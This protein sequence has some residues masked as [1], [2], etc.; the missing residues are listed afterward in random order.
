MLMLFLFAFPYIFAFAYV[1]KFT[2]E[3]SRGHF[4]TLFLIKRGLIAVFLISFA[5]ISKEWQLSVMLAIIVVTTI[6]E[7]A[8]PFEKCIHNRI[9]VLVSNIALICFYASMFMFLDKNPDADDNQGESL[10]IA[11]SIFLI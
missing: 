9:T 11:I 4:M 6:L 10:G 3:T 5:Y 2:K 7:F 1:V 8:Y